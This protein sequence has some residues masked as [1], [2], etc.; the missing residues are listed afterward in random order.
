[1]DILIIYLLF[2]N[3]VAFFLMLVDKRRAVKNT[4]RIPE[5][6]LLG[7]AAMG[8]SL[9]AVMGMR[10]FRHKTLHLRFSLGLP[11]LL[12]LHIMLAILLI[13]LK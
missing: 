8:G 11:L 12:A 5:A 7:I 13:C 1:M 6:T 9:G 10:L 2:V 3:M 4:W